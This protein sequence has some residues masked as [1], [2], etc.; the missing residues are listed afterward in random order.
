[1]QENQL[2]SMEEIA[3]HIVTM[4]IKKAVVGG[5]DREDVYK[6]MQ[7]MHELYQKCINNELAKQKGTLDAQQ[8][9]IAEQEERIKKMRSD[10]SKKEPEQEELIQKMRSELS[11]K[12]QKMQE[13]IQ[14]ERE[15]QQKLTAQQQEIK[16]QAEQLAQSQLMPQP[17]KE[18]MVADPVFEEPQ[19][20]AQEI[21]ASQPILVSTPSQIDPNIN[22]IIDEAYKEKDRIIRQA[23]V[24]AEYEGIKIRAN[25]REEKEQ[26]EKWKRQI[27]SEKEQMSRTLMKIVEGLEMNGDQIKELVARIP[28]S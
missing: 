22:L 27:Q 6:K 9:T 13:L 25:H 28:N 10:L 14:R 19:V 21:P 1:M 20:V 2:L 7:E 3:K 24:E 12:E 16:R 23:R 8:S 18:P 5:F 4:D 17:R 26:H 11:R 15:W